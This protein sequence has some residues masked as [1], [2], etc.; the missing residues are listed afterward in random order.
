MTT[1]DTSSSSLDAAWAVSIAGLRGLLAAMI[2]AM[3]GLPVGSTKMM[4]QS[5]AIL[6][7]TR[8]VITAEVTRYQSALSAKMFADPMWRRR[9]FAELGGLHGMKAWQ[10]RYLKAANAEAFPP[11][12]TASAS[13]NTGPNTGPE[14]APNIE[15]C[16]K[17]KNHNR[18][19]TDS[20]G[21]FRLAPLPRPHQ[22][23]THGLTPMS[24]APNQAVSKDPFAAP[25]PLHS[26]AFSPYSAR[27]TKYLCENFGRVQYYAPAHDPYGDGIT[28]DPDKAAIKPP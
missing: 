26:N 1:A 17:P 5:R 7:L 4:R 11:R 25:I 21:Q 16:Q 8:L 13:P 22:A 10:Q 14:T 27:D 20:K 9:V 3:W 12:K 15:A 24:A 23:R 19:K 6:R 28:S 2:E 18:Y